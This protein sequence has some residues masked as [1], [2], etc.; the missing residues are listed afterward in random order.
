MGTAHDPHA[1]AAWYMTVTCC[2]PR[3]HTLR[4]EPQSSSSQPLRARGVPRRRISASGPFRT[5]IFG[6]ALLP[7]SLRGRAQMAYAHDFLRASG[8]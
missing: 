4:S 1:A 3:H 5:S 6:E 8:A 2:P 7:N